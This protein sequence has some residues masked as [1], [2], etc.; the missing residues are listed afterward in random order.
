MIMF[1][2][3]LLSMINISGN[4][5]GECQN[6]HFMSNNIFSE[7][8]AFYEI[9]WKICDSQTGHILKYIRKK[10]LEIC[11]LDTQGYRHTLRI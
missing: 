2:W 11:I 9:M 3:I 6:T 1:R 8:L 4:I 7:I 5:C 10:E